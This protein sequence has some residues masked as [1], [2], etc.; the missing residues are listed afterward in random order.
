VEQGTRATPPPGARARRLAFVAT[1]PVA[2]SMF[3]LALGVFGLVSLGKLPVDLLPEISYPTLTVRTAY[4]GAAP[5]DVEDRVSVR[6]QEALSTL[7][8]LVRTSSVSRAGFSDVLLEFTWGSNMTFAVQE[9]RDRLD[10]V[11][12]PR[13]AERPLILRY[14]PNLDPILRIGVR[15]PKGAPE[16]F[17]KD[18]FI[19]LRW[20]AE[21]R[22]ERELE[23]IEGVAA[24]QVR[25]GLEEEILVSIDPQKLSGQDLDPGLIGQRLAQ[26][27]LNASSG[28]IREG[29]TDYLVRTLNE[30]RDI[31]E[32]ENL[33][34]ERRGSA[35]IRIRDVAHVSRTF[36]EREVITRIDGHEAV[37]IAV[38]R[39]AGA[40]IVEVADAVTRA[41]FGDARQQA[42]AAQRVEEG[43]TDAGSLSLEER[44][45]LTFLAWTM[46][47]DAQLEL[48]SDQSTFI[49]A[50]VD[51]VRD[52]AL[53]G[54]LLA[55]IVMWFFLRRFAATLIVALAIPISVVVTF[56]PMF[57]MDVSLNIMSLGGL[58]LG[59]G[60]LVD[61]AIVVL[62]SITRCREEGD[63]L[64]E[65]AVRGVGEVSGAIIAST[66]TTVAVFAPIVFVHGIAGQIFGDQAVTVVSALLVSLLVAVLFIPMLASRRALASSGLGRGAL[67]WIPDAVRA[68]RTPLRS[69]L[70]FVRSFSDEFLFGGLRWS[71]YETIPNVVRI[72]L[73]ALRLAGFVIL[74]LLVML[75]ALVGG[76]L[77]VVFWIPRTLF[78]LAWRSVDALYPRG[79]ALALAAPWLVLLAAGVLSWQA[80]E[81]AKTLGLELLP[82]IHQGEFTA[83]V[84]LGVGTPIE[85]SDGV[86]AELD[87]ELRALEGVALTALTIGVEADTLTREIEGEHTARITVRLAPSHSS[88]EAEEVVVARAR[89]LFESHAEVRTVDVTRPTPFAIDA[90]IAVE[91][92]G[93]DLEQLAEVAAEVRKRMEGIF[94]LA[95]IRT[96]VRPGH[97]EARVTFDRDKTLE[98]GLD[99][100]AVSD[101]VRDQ[102]LGTVSTRFVE[103]DERID[104]RVRADQDVLAT[105]E[106]VFDLVV[107]PTAGRP[108]PLRSVASIEEVRGPAEIRRIGNQRAVVVTAAATGLDLGGVARRIEASLDGLPH[109]DKVS[110]ELGG[111]KREMDAGSRS[112][113]LALLLAIFLVYVVMAT[114]FES[115]LQPFIILFSVPLAAVGVVFALDLLSVPLSVVVFIG[116]ILLAGIVVN[117]AIVL[118]DRI[119][120]K[121]GAGLTVRDAVL[122]AGRAR[123]RPILMTTATTVLGLLPLTGW[124][125]AL[126]FAESLSALP[127]GLGRLCDAFL[128]AG[129]GEGA[130]LRAPMAIT[131]IAGLTT[132]TLLTLF[133]IPVIYS[134]VS[135]ER[136]PD[137]ERATPRAEGG[138]VE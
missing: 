72:L 53:I 102:V 20:L 97:P 59:I 6:I 86:F 10:G 99:L 63:E 46:R 133:V 26:E 66:L 107:N 95:D 114:Q 106:D 22:L 122:E 76:V 128:G 110:V 92:R 77:W 85:V 8:G 121:R 13:D 115:L 56:A 1:R 124:L 50:A 2:I 135:F 62:E 89:R 93:Y 136:R 11:F 84:G 75:V 5:E 57:I 69:S 81:R 83:H 70:D 91:V 35:T 55:V 88:P 30:F 65:S 105:I 45:Q 132:S 68:R 32:I 118:V 40:N 52:A 90:P 14:D 98:Y 116:L 104:I 43:R 71:W 96:T 42:Q 138:P 49:G 41:V 127:G 48:L 18:V 39:E 58:A 12:L 21:K 28:Q 31:E 3:F 24:V 120:A 15:P 60:M 54:A 74:R 123:L 36:A 23:S 130:E 87:R 17:D 113:Q 37:E 109:P 51:D 79:L 33:A 29:S 47:D 78:D 34:V 25:G 9:V 27:N 125:G 103:G 108:V 101:Y 100:G 112:L 111:Q 137:P 67:G 94:G 119:N 61:N 44:Q 117:N 4:A 129:A 73:R 19:R 131:V 134:L 38:Y 16:G 80:W 64:A 7:P 126:P 82:E